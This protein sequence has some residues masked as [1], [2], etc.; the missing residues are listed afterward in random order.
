MF[1]YFAKHDPFIVKGSQKLPPKYKEYRARSSRNPTIPLQLFPEMN[2]TDHLKR[3]YLVNLDG[4]SYAHRLV[5]LLATNSVVM[6]E[7]TYAQEF[8][9]HMLRPWVH[10]VPFHFKANMETARLEHVY[11]SDAAVEPYLSSGGRLSPG[12]GGGGGRGGIR[13]QPLLFGILP[14]PL[15]FSATPRP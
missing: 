3:K 13:P 5:K 2:Y 11:V 9:Y 14:Q 4:H 1:R 6:K 7:E 12:G 8:Y 15:L 10:Y